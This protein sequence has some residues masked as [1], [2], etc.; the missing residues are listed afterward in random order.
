MLLA[1]TSDRNRLVNELDKDIARLLAAYSEAVFNKD[2]T[3]FIRLYDPRVR[4][5]DAWGVW[6]HEGAGAWQLAVEAWFTSLGTERVRVTFDDVD[7]VVGKDVSSVNA[8]VT[9]AGLSAEGDQLR[10]MQNRLTWVLRTIG[11]VPRIIHEHTSAPV[12]FED[13][14]AILSRNKAS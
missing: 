1:A 13:M 3:T 8:T 4:I 7:V 6:V 12:G 9:Y 10:A 14:K 5:F 11:H 2:V